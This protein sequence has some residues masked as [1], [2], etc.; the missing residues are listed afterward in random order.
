MLNIVLG[1]AKRIT[2]QFT[3]YASLDLAAG[4]GP[5]EY[6]FPF[7]DFEPDDENNRDRASTSSPGLAARGTLGVRFHFPSPQSRFDA[8]LDARY[9][10]LEIEGFSD[11]GE[12]DTIVSFAGS[13]LFHG[14]T[15][16]FGATF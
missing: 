4:F 12:G 5:T 13:D 9:Q 15:A 14:P 1:L 3:P 16:A 10:A 7:D 8:Y 2:P 6:D 11:S